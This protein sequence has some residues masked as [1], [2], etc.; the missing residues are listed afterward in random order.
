MKTKPTPSGVGFLLF[1]DFAV[2]KVFAADY[3]LRAFVE[4]LAFC[5]VYE[6]IVLIVFTDNI[7]IYPLCLKAHK[8]VYIHSACL[9]VGENRV[10]GTEDAGLR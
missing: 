2:F 1:Y 5:R 7:N 4:D 3:D 10:F 6:E 9:R 8:Q